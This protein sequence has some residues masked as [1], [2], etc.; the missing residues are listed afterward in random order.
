[1][2]MHGKS[3]I[4]FDELQKNALHRVANKFMNFQFM[5]LTNIR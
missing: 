3:T 4:R 2:E 1:M 5:T